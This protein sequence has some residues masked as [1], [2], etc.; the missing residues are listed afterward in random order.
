MK[1]CFKPEDIINCLES[2]IAILLKN[3]QQVYLDTLIKTVY[4]IIFSD[5]NKW[6]HYHVKEK[7]H[8]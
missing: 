4:D 1:K 5:L 2:P 3:V 6:K 8:W 7:N